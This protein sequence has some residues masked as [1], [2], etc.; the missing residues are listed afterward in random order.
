MKTALVARDVMTPDRTLYSLGR[1]SPRKTH[2][3]GPTA[4]PKQNNRFAGHVSKLV[5]NIQAKEGS[6]IEVW[7]LLAVNKFD[8]DMEDLALL[9]MSPNSG[10]AEAFFTL[11]DPS[12]LAPLAPAKV[13]RMSSK[14]ER[15]MYGGAFSAAIMAPTEIIKESQL[16]SHTVGHTSD[17]L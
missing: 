17:A 16:E 6:A 7:T 8:S 13:L 1:S 11:A 5:S 9:D 10:V 15:F 2:W 3:R 12:I 4:A 14:T